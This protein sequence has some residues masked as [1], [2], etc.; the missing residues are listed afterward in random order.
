MALRNGVQRLARGRCAVA[1]FELAYCFLTLCKSRHLL[2]FKSAELRCR[3]LHEAP[4]ASRTANKALLTGKL[5]VDTESFS[6]PLKFQSGC[7]LYFLF[8]FF[9]GLF[10]RIG[11]RRAPSVEKYMQC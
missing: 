5:S 1:E 7:A 3:T 10:F 6:F 4:A 9:T 11:I 8:F 2:S